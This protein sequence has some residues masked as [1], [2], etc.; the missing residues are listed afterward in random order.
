MATLYI[1]EYE[2]IVI[3]PVTGDTVPL[4]GDF[5]TAHSVPV[6]VTSTQSVALQPTTE[7][8]TLTSDT[9]CLFAVGLSPDAT[10][11]ARYLPASQTRYLRVTAGEK[12]AVIGAA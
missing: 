2:H 11:S 3:D 7:F 9:D 12:I 10:S 8:I 1:E 5:S 4:F 6:T